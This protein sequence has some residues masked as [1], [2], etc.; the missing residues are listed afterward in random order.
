MRIVRRLLVV[1][2]LLALL[3]GGA[4]AVATTR[5]PSL[6]AS[7]PVTI[8][9]TEASPPFV[10]GDRTVRQAR[11]VDRETLGY[12]FTLTNGSRLPVTVTGVRPVGPEATLLR[13][14]GV[15]GG[16]GALPEVGAGQSAAVTVTMLMTD[17][18]RLSARAASL[19]SAVELVTEDVFGTSHEVTVALP[20][21]LRVGSAREMYCPRATAYSRPPG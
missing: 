15:A 8:S 16:D 1:A 18:E 13:L 12:T 17:C 6:T 11:Y 14:E 20:E 2:V 19:V 4:A 10:L 21:E 7:G 9:G 5:D 3:V